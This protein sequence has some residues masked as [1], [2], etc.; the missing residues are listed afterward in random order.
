MNR[1]YGK[2]AKRLSRKKK[3][4]IKGL[5]LKYQQNL[6]DSQH[7]VDKFFK[8]RGISKSEGDEFIREMLDSALSLFN[9][10]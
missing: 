4:Y 10:K 1:I 7:D 2:N 9:L 3:K 6:I 5:Y 8:D